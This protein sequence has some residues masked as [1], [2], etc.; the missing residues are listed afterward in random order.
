MIRVGRRTTVAAVA[1]CLVVAAGALTF[2]SSADVTRYRTAAATVGD[3]TRTVTH[4]GTIAASRRSDL[5]FATDGTVRKVAAGVG[6]EVE[7][8]DV[9]VR[10]DTT[11]LRAE[12]V[13]AEADLA[14]AEA[15]LEDV[16]D[17]QIDTVTRSLGGG[18]TSG[19]STTRTGAVVPAVVSS[20]T[21]TTMRFASSTSTDLEAAVAE[22]TAQQAAVT[23]AQS[24]ATAALATAKEALATQRSSCEDP[25]ADDGSQAGLTQACTEALGSVEEAQ[26]VVAQRQ[27]SLQSALERLGATLTAAVERL[28]EADPEP[29][30]E[31]SAE[32]SAGPRADDDAEE[33]P[34]AGSAA[35]AD[36]DAARSAPDGAAGGDTSSPSTGGQS[37]TTAT[38]ADLASA[39]ADVDTAEAA[40]ASARADLEAATITAPF[41]GTVAAVDVVGGDTV[42]AADRGIV[43]IGD[44]ATTATLSV[45]VDELGEL[46]VD[47]QATVTTAAGATAT[48]R[49][50]AIGLAPETA[51]GESSTTTY[52]VTVLLDGDVSAPEG[53]A[54]SVALVTGTAADVV[55]VPTSAITRRTATSG[56][57]L[58]LGADGEVSRTQVGLGPVSG[59]VAAV[60]E[61]LDE[62][63]RVVLAD[64]EADLPSSGTA[65]TRSITG[66]GRGIGP[67]VG[68]TPGG[69]RAS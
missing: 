39:Q 38:A 59:T 33:T 20:A 29:S 18:A 64:L 34:P 65:D 12:V 66:A 67:Q 60:T 52:A 19:A 63:A 14:E 46:A 53:S 5:A 48:G 47:Q 57:V 27:Q 16:S 10:L 36:R 24:E 49:V 68:G 7:A 50:S 23:T 1:A 42:A 62:G 3:V 13:R 26:D 30:T 45:P 43:L 9:L 51:D 41:D 61:G 55:T 37:G 44:G 31:P 40:L 17:G 58:V 15:Y 25:D 32:P 22:L 6:D 28:G 35:G 8:G 69:R 56:T 21:A 4:D 11:D 54:A 2:G